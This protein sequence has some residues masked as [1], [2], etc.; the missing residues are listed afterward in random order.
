MVLLQRQ[1]IRL[2][3]HHGLF[4]VLHLANHGQL[5]FFPYFGFFRINA[6]VPIR[7][8]QTCMFGSSSESRGCCAS[9]NR[10]NKNISNKNF[11]SSL[12][13][14]MNF[15]GK[16]EKQSLRYDNSLRALLRLY[17]LSIAFKKEKKGKEGC[18]NLLRFMAVFSSSALPVQ[19]RI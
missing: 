10:P 16:Q 7:I 9:Q 19:R 12:L 14:S 3:N 4:F 6:Q 17:L 5:K 18:V 15:L 2:A 8:L 1:K 13:A 11:F